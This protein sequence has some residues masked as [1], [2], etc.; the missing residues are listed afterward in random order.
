M[1]FN[2][3]TYQ[4]LDSTNEEAVRL[5][6]KGELTVPTVIIANYQSE[7][8]GYGSNFWESAAGKNLTFSITCFPKFIEPSDQFVLTQITSLSLLEVVSEV[9]RDK[10]VTIKWPNDLYVADK[11]IAGVLIRNFVKSNEIDFSVIGVGLN[12]NQKIFHSDAPNPTSLFIET[13]QTFRTEEVLT[14]ILQRFSAY[15]NNLTNQ[16]QRDSINLQ[17]VKNLYRLEQ[18]NRFKDKEGIF[19]AKIVGIDEFGQLKLVSDD[20]CERVYGFK[21]VE[22]LQD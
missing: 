13:G 15:M 14:K 1:D 10:Q 11:K 19:T 3:L 6:Q 18:P 12:V 16:A 22:F 17:Y 20:G 4:T 21:E 2:L 8:K 9:I 5:Y 7:G